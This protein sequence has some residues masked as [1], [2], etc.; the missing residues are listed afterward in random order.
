MC[1]DFSKGAKN[2]INASQSNLFSINYFQ[3]RFFVQEVDFHG[4]C[5][6]D[7]PSTHLILQFRM[8]MPPSLSHSLS[9]FSKRNSS[10]QKIERKSFFFGTYVQ[11]TSENMFDISL[12]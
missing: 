7:I 12:R 8:K 5:A 6:V 2:G 1:R 11:K 10:K 3:S 4:A 9:G